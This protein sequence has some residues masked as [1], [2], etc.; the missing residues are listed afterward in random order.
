M[1]PSYR[2]NA[3]GRTSHDS[4][5]KTRVGIA[6]EI[7]TS[8]ALASG[9]FTT[10]SVSFANNELSANTIAETAAVCLA[11]GLASYGPEKMADKPDWSRRRHK[12]AASLAVLG[13]G[14]ASFGMVFSVKQAWRSGFDEGN[15]NLPPN[16]EYSIG[17]IREQAD[18][19]LIGAGLAFSA[20]GAATYAI[21]E[22]RRH[23]RQSSESAS[24]I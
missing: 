12:V 21:S 5:K 17:P 1:T 22:R 8:L 7:T 6:S 3:L 10:I 13:L 11:A 18:D 14:L 9:I 20:T 16:P 15:H 24:N 4:K 19:L 23:T 2:E